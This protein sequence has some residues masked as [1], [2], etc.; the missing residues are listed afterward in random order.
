MAIV[1]WISCV[2]LLLIAADVTAADLERYEF[3]EVHMGVPFQITLYAPTQVVANRAAMAAYERIGQLDDILSDYDRESELMRFCRS[4]KPGRPVRVSKELFTVLARA[5]VVSQRSDGAFDVSVGPLVRL[6]RRARRQKRLPD[7]DD[8]TDAK[9]AVGYKAIRLDSKRRTVELLKTDM[10]LDLGGIAKG[11]A[12]DEALAALRKQGVSRA[13]IDG[14]GDIVVGDSPPEKPGWRI[15]IAR[16]GA[17]DGPPSRYLTLKNAAVA[18]SGDAFQAVEIGKLRYSHIVDPQTGIG[19]TVR[20]SVTV[21]AR[22]GMTA[23]ALASAVSVLGVCRARGFLAKFP[24]T[25]ASIVVLESK[26]AREHVFGQRVTGAAK[27][28]KLKR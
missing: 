5:E 10:R 4:A 9:R 27:R 21:V 19:L 18:T 6:W 26:M 11:Y 20:S 17:E 22:N 1:H 23:D 24:G 15:G 14:G 8:L 16:L 12:G 13:L 3:S 7:P 28:P 25:T 2:G